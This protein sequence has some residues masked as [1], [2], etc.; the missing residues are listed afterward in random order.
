MKKT[1]IV[2]SVILVVAFALF[3]VAEATKKLQKAEEFAQ[4]GIG[5][6][7]VVVSRVVDGMTTCYVAQHTK[8]GAHDISCV[9]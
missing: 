1:I 5:N 9:K 3:G 2:V 6:D 7:M 8:Y 4:V